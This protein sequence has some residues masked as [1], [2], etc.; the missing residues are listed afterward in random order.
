MVDI[1]QQVPRRLTSLLVFEIDT[2]EPAAS[3]CAFR[4]SGEAGFPRLQPLAFH[5]QTGQKEKVG[6][7][8]PETKTKTKPQYSVHRVH[9]G[10]TAQLDELA[11]A[12]G[13]VYSRTL[14][15]FWRTVRHKGLWLKPKHLMRLISTDPDQLLHSHTVDATVQAFFAG[16]SSW[17]ERR[18]TD[19]TAR[20]PRHRKWYFRIEYK[21]SAITLKDSLLILSNGRGKTP[22]VLF[23]EWAL[24]HTVVIHWTGSQYEAL[25]TYQI[26]KGLPQEQEVSL[27]ER[28]TEH[29]AG[30]DLGE[31][32]PAVSYDGQRAHLLNGRLLRSKRQYRNKLIARMDAKI[33]HCKKG[34]NRRR[35]LLRAKQKRLSK[36]SHQIQEIEHKQTSYLVN[37]LHQEGVEKLVIGDVRTIRHGL[38]KGSKTNQKLHQWS[39]GSI[40]HKLT[41]KAERL[42]MHIVI[43]EERFT[44]RT[45]PVCGHRRKSAPAGRVFRCTS[46]TCQWQGHRDGVGAANIRAKYRGEFGGRHVVGAMAP[47]TGCGYVPQLRVSL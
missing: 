6:M 40:R 7:R 25:A 17:R 11:H 34:S 30:I 43:H 1:T 26:G 28:R 32:H 4:P 2:I 22:V 21:S 5:F 14:L 47:P 36:L 10:R 46:R 37:T 33:S 31:V 20:P 45:C 27:Q 13:Q 9:L 18:K 23:W 3:C 15:F 38:D 24:P 35:K 39:F 19:P 16:L 8:R 12:C 29:S 44:S 42:G 41:Y